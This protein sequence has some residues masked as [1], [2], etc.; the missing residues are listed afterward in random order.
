MA[1]TKLLPVIEDFALTRYHRAHIAMARPREIVHLHEQ[2]LGAPTGCRRLVV[3][4]VGARRKR[5]VI[6]VA[7]SLREGATP[8]TESLLIT[9]DPALVSPQQSAMVIGPVGTLDAALPPTFTILRS[10]S[11]EVGI[12]YEPAL[13]SEKIQRHRLELVRTGGARWRTAKERSNLRRW[14]NHTPVLTSIKRLDPT[15]PAVKYGRTIYPTRVVHPEDVPR[16]FVS[17]HNSR[18]LGGVVQK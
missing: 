2:R 14:E 10:L 9:D 12:N 6:D 8:R 3:L 16:I 7:P 18:K 4:D 11:F 15:H 13:A 1:S 17:G 5:P